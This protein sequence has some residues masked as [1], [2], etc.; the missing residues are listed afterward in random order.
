MDQTQMIH[1]T[2]VISIGFINQ[3]KQNQIVPFYVVD[4]YDGPVRKRLYVNYTFGKRVDANPP[5]KFDNNLGNIKMDLFCHLSMKGAIEVPIC[6]G[7]TEDQQTEMVQ[8][9]LENMPDKTRVLVVLEKTDSDD[10]PFFRAI[11]IRQKGSDDMA[12]PNQVFTLKDLGLTISD[13][14]KE[15]DFKTGEPL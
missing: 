9:A 8:M 3:D 14:F 5:I 13:P 15:F 7:E 1:A 10:V 12:Q 6:V 2:P 4:L 11:N